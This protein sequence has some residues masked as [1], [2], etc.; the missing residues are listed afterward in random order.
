MRFV[1]PIRGGTSL[2]DTFTDGSSTTGRGFPAEGENTAL[3]PAAHTLGHPWGA[4]RTVPS[5]AQLSKNGGRGATLVEDA[6]R[7]AA[8]IIGSGAL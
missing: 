7:L 4:L 5:G 2:S 1:P 6:A 8:E 3:G